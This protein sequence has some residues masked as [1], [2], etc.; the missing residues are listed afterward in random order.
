MVILITGRA[1]PFNDLERRDM[2][3]ENMIIED[4]IKEDIY[5]NYRKEQ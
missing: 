4:S 3:S 5:S 1:T 2:L